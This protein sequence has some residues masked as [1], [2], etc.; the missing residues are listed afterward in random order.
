[1]RNILS[2]VPGTKFSG[3]E[4]LQWAK[5]QV[6][7][8]TSHIKQ[9]VHIIRSFGNIKPERYYT[10]ATSYQGTGCGE[11]LKKPLIKKVVMQ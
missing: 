2:Y 6:N 10:I 11:V 3:F 7:H 4:I 1:M 5:F 9:G 8:K